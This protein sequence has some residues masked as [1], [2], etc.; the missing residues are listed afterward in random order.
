MSIGILTLLRNLEM[1][2]MQTQG[3]KT[4]IGGCNYF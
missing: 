2:K 3:K 1:T 4:N